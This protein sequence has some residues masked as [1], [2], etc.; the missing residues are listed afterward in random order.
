[1]ETIISQFISDWGSLGAF[2]CILGFLIWDN[3]RTNRSRQ[4]NHGTI[5]SAVDSMGGKIDNLHEK[6]ELVDT[7]M[8]GFKTQINDRMTLLEKQIEIVPDNH[9]KKQ[10]YAEEKKQKTHLKQL[11]DLMKLGP[12]LHRIIQNANINI[13]GDHIFVGS[14]HNGN[15]S[16]SGIP[17]YKF[18]IIAER[19]S[20]A[21]VDQ[22]REFAHMYKDSDILRYDSLPVL[23]E[24][25]G[26]IH[27]MVPEEG[28]V[29]LS[30]YDDI[31]WRRMRG[32]GIKQ[33]A[34]R[35]T[36]DSKG[37][38]SGFV[39]VVK[40]DD[41]TKLKLEHPESCGKDLEEIYKEAE[42]KDKK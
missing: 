1:M 25:Q 28:D 15:S 13:G 8:E 16:L 38:P 3:W 24:Q 30:K 39:G 29:E 42:L 40:Y 23:L 32:R 18:D 27:F 26:M 12:K 5:I 4:T 35:I 11:D 22:D 33:I 41:I 17:Y 9:I 14:F 21:K 7:K 19:F 2:L 20:P 37:T 34:I 10:E 6:I 36:R 31:I